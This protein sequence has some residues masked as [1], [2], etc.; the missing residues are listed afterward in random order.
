MKLIDYTINDGTLGAPNGVMYQYVLARNGL[1]VNAVRDGLSATVQIEKFSKQ[2]LGLTEMD[3][4]VEVGGRIPASMLA[5]ML[6]TAYRNTGKEI[7]FYLQHSPWRVL[8]PDQVMTGGSVRPVDRYDE[9]MRGALVEV[10]SHHRMKPFFSL[11]DDADERNGFRV[12]TVL[13]NLEDVPTILTRVGIYGHF[14]II[15]SDWVY[16]MPV[17]VLDVG[18]DRSRKEQDY[19]Y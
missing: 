8:L 13:G 4:R 9:D 10:H 1:F 19:G 15:P 6:Y 7:L 14:Q 12:Y 11:Q 2:V 17:G 3:V 5:W 18:F 16:E